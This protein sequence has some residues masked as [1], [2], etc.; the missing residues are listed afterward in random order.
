[1][2]D[3]ELRAQLERHHD[4]S[5]GWALNC[6][7]RNATEAEDVLQTAYLKVL[8]GRARYDGRAA[9]KT[10]L[11]AVIR[12]TAAD[13]RRRGWLRR[14]GLARYG[15]REAEAV[16]QDSPPD[17]QHRTERQAAF[18]KAL[19]ALP[20]RQQEVLHLVFYQDLS[21]SEAADVLGVSVGSAR[22]HY[23]RGKQRLRSLLQPWGDSNE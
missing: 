10:W 19:G 21:L 12:L 3:S 15:R 9:F 17:I 6:C 23:E 5:Y 8:D 2:D 1:M 7:G 4:A 11:L 14:L 22:R 20:R 16:E 13:E 18:Q